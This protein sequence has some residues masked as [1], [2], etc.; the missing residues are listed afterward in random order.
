MVPPN[1]ST[2]TT[3]AGSDFLQAIR[4]SGVV[5]EQQVQKLEAK[6]TEGE[7]PSDPVELAAQLV[8]DEVL[9]AYQ[10]HQIQKGRT[11]GLIFSSYVILDFLGKG[12]MGKVYKARH[13][14]MGRVVALKILDPRYVSS[15]RSVARFQREMQLVGRLDHPNVVRAYDAD[16]FAD[17]HFIAMEYAAGVTL[18]DLL[19]AR[20]ALSPA[21]VVYYA[22]QAADGLAHAHAQG[23]LHRDIKPSNLLL[24]PGRKVKVLDFGL[25]TLLEKEEVQTAL[26]TVGMAVGTPDYIS[27]EQARMVKLDGRSDLYSL[28]CTIYH[29]LS[30][31][32]PFKG[33]SSMDCIVGRITGQAVPL[34]EVKPGLP[35]RLIQVVEKMMATNPD[36]R[37]QTADETATALRGLLR[38]KTAAAAPEPSAPAVPATTSAPKP[39]PA[40]VT[41]QAASPLPARTGARQSKSKS[42]APRMA[43]V[44]RVLKANPVFA[45]LGVTAAAVLLVVGMIALLQPSNNGSSESQQETAENTSGLNV[46]ASGEGSQQPNAAAE[47]AQPT[48]PSSKR[49]EPANPSLAARHANTPQ[50]SAVIANANRGV[51][52]SKSEVTTDAGPTTTGTAARQPALVIENPKNGATV[53]M[54]QELTCRIESDGW[55]VF[56][57]QADIPGQPWWC[58]APA[59][60]M[61]DGRFSTMV[62]FGDDFTPHGMKFRIVGIVTPTREE[63]L[64]FSIGSKQQTVP[65][66]YPQ[67]VEVVVTHQ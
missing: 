48:A 27:P 65:Q 63:A 64:K 67:S 50:P 39:V 21:D 10:A 51:T 46:P 32:L 62:V 37:Y 4:S 9:T 6:I 8:K 56:F 19:K 13:R 16:R 36:D 24:T 2:T 66:G 41:S 59:E 55:P 25:G 61:E 18:E 31:Q 40:G 43:W 42:D 12:T 5:P 45:A 3:D 26:T 60:R 28:G 29:L 11:E 33:E 15:D 34:G 14:M 53:G 49:E 35:P 47:N 30:G 52:A 20:G 23:I 7:Y 22:S 38:P 1:E 57:I 44:T 54:R 17:C 58:Q